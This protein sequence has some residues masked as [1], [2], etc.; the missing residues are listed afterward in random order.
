MPSTPH[1][2]S[3]EAAP[4]LRM[5]VE[6]RLRGPKVK[7]DPSE[8]VSAYTTD[9]K[10]LAAADWVHLSVVFDAVHIHPATVDDLAILGPVDGEN[11]K[12]WSIEGP[13]SHRPG[14]PGAGA[15]ISVLIEVAMSLTGDPGSNWQPYEPGRYRLRSVRARA[16]LTRPRDD[17]DFRIVRFALEAEREAPANRPRFV[18]AATQDVIPARMSRQ[19]STDFEIEAGAELEIEAGGILEITQ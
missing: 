18:H 15:N 12:R 17:Y 3:V 6:P 8:L 11:A 4:A 14:D 10:V 5:W 1:F 13:L 2:V 7:P 19:V 9:T 16:T